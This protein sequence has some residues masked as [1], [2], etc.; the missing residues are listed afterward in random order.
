[1]E[2]EANRF[3]VLPFVGILFDL[4]SVWL[5]IFVDPVFFWLHIPGGMLFAGVFA[6]ESLLMLKEMWLMKSSDSAEGG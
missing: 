4:A 1:M 2:P 5:K 3:I 6:V